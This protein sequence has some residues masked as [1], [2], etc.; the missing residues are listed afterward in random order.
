M[1]TSIPVTI[2]ALAL[3]SLLVPLGANAQSTPAVFSVSSHR[4]QGKEGSLVR[5]N[6][7]PYV[8]G[9][10]V[11]NFRSTGEKVRQVSIG[12]TSLLLSSDD[13]DCLSS[14][15]SER[16]SE[17]CAATLLYLQQKPPGQTIAHAGKTRMTV[18][19]DKNLYLF[20]VV[21]SSGNP[22]YT[23]I[24]IQPERPRE[25]K[26]LTSIEQITLL[27]RGF[28]VATRKKYLLNPELNRRIRNFLLLA[29]TESSLPNAATKAGISMNVVRKLEQLGRQ[30]SISSSITQTNKKPSNVTSKRKFVPFPPNPF[31][32]PPKPLPFPPKP[33]PR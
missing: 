4:A 6:I 28:V 14:T 15:S 1:K 32:F 22:K 12:G 33:F 2:I 31:P 25:S 23:V 29:Q 10:T 3:G 19:T 20:E 13:P 21:L 26:P 17:A 16:S 30:A 18:S 11:L 8:T 5:V 9:S 27:N 24:E 7:Y